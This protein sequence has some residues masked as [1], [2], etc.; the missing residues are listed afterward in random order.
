MQFLCAS[1]HLQD[2]TRSQFWSHPG[3]S[4][5]P[6]SHRLDTSEDTEPTDKEGPLRSPLQFW[7]QA[8]TRQHEAF[9]GDQIYK[10]ASVVSE[11][12]LATPFL[13]PTLVLQQ[14]QSIILKDSEMVP[15]LLQFLK[16]YVHAF[17]SKDL[18]SKL[19]YHH[20]HRILLHQRSSSKIIFKNKYWTRLVIDQ[21]PQI[22]NSS[23]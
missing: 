10:S 4:L 1:E 23:H 15:P 21:S 8:L 19:Q 14:H 22:L 17:G 18:L 6:S 12:S 3:G 7:P 5:R 20:S 9:I 13:I 2:T 16:C 11:I